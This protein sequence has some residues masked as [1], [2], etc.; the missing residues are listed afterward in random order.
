MIGEK[1]TSKNPVYEGCG[2]CKGNCTQSKTQNYRYSPG[3][4]LHEQM[5]SFEDSYSTFDYRGLL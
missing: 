1:Y 4:K 2:Y 3:E 5:I